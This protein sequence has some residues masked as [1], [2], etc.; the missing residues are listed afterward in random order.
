MTSYIPCAELNHKSFDSGLTQF[1]SHRPPLSPTPGA[2]IRRAKSLVVALQLAA[3]C[4]A[5][6][7][8]PLHR[9]CFRLTIRGSGP[10]AAMR[11]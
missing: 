5:E 7:A 8:L 11:V 9:K 10:N 4:S 2:L 6:S 3:R 1:T